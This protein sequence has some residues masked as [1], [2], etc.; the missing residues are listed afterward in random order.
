MESKICERGWGCGVQNVGGCRVGNA[1]EQT[2]NVKKEQG[3]LPYRVNYLTYRKNQTPGGLWSCSEVSVCILP[4]MRL[5]SLQKHPTY[6]FSRLYTI[7]ICYDEAT[8]LVLV[9]PVPSDGNITQVRLIRAV[10]L[11]RM[12]ESTRLER[13]SASASPSPAISLHDIWKGRW[14]PSSAIHA[15]GPRCYFQLA[16]GCST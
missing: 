6:F 13:P 12:T 9:M 8:V 4:F 3:S 15:C 2:E 16:T 5:W 10:Q 1:L 11:Q 14:G 7:H